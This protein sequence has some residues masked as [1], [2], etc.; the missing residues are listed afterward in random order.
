M[1]ASA[2]TMWSGGLRTSSM[3][4]EFELETDQPKS[5]Y[6]TNV[7]PAPAE[8]F[9]GSIGACFITSFVWYAWHKHLP[10]DEITVSVKAPIKDSK[11]G[12]EITEIILK[13]KVWSKCDKQSKMEKC[14]EYAKTHCP[15]TKA[16]K[17]PVSYSV[18]Y[19][20]EKDKDK[21]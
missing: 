19:K 6:G 12:E 2:I 5:Y 3:I 11:D 7:A 1:K 9:A 4:R 15:L 16:L 13:V 20:L 21:E 14:F 18:K 8:I 10:L 17:I